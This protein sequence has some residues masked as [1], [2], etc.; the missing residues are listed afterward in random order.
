[1][2]DRRRAEVVGA[3]LAILE[4]SGSE[5]VTMRAIADRLGIRAPSLYRQFPDK[6]AIEIALIAAGFE[7]QAGG[8]RGGHGD[9]RATRPG[10]R[11]RLSQPGPSLIRTSIV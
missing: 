6:R 9:G 4:E 7:E 2:S 10:D 8:V 3:A 5:A 1:M 11:R